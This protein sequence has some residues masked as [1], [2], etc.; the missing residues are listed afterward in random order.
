[1]DQWMREKGLRWLWNGEELTGKSNSEG[2]ERERER[3]RATPATT[4]HKQAPFFHQL[5]RGKVL[6][7]ATTDIKNLNNGREIRTHT[8]SMPTYKKNNNTHIQHDN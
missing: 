8:L 2:T 5:V 4:N 3:E 7:G 1:M 6:D